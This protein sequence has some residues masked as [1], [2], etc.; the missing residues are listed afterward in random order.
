MQAAHCGFVHF[1]CGYGR[2]LRLGGIAGAAGT[3]RQSSDC[4]RRARISA[5]WL[6][7][8]AT[9]RGNS[10]CIRRCRYAQRAKLCPHGIFLDGH[11]EKY[12][13]WSDRVA[14][15]LGK[16][17]PVVEMV[18]IDEAYLDLAGTERLQG[19]PLAAADT[20]LRTITKSTGLP[21]SGGLATTRLVAK[22]A[23]DKR[24]RED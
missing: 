17:S 6:P 2:V 13:E 1:A 3:S 23:S 9:R 19:P 5:G 8:R 18:S 14:A 22:V 15:I 12:G 10:E 21:C 16:F 20:L 4:G 11:H 7:R 24:S